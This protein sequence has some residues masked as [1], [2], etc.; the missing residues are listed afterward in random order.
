MTT[1]ATPQ[2]FVKRW[3]S[4]DTAANHGEVEVITR[5]KSCGGVL[6]YRVYRHT[7]HYIGE[8]ATEYCIECNQKTNTFC[9]VCKK[10]LCNTQLAANQGPPHKG[11]SELNQ[12]DP[13]FISITFNYGKFTGK[14]QKICAIYSC[15]HKS[16]QASLEAG[17]A[18]VRGQHSDEE[19][20][21]P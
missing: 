15:W 11:N 7:K 5:M 12:H 16:L 14:P 9:I 18:V 8:G 10:W 2:R 17:G 13:K 6:V 4:K 20:E 19:S 3:Y 21:I 1:G